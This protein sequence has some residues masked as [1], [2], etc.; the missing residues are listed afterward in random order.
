MADEL[1]ADL[2]LVVEDDD[3]IR[4]TLKALLEMEGYEV[5]V[6]ENGEIGFRMLKT[7]T[8]PCLILLDVMMPVMNGLEFLDIMKT[9]PLHHMLATIPV[10]VVSAGMESSDVRPELTHGFLKK[11][12]DIDVLLKTVARF[13]RKR[14]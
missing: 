1:K 9:S 13:C 3:G 5:A 6:A 8:R 12:L 10:I 14:K 11:P 2:V 4:S 7:I